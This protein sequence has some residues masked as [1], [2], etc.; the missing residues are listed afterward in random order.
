MKKLLLSF[1][2]LVVLGVGAYVW[3]CRIADDEI[4]VL[5]SGDYKLIEWEITPAVDSVKSVVAC[6]P[7]AIGS[8]VHLEYTADGKVSL[9]AKSD[10]GAFHPMLNYEWEL[11][12]PCR[13]EWF[14]PDYM[15]ECLYVSKKSEINPYR[16]SFWLRCG[17]TFG[18]SW[19][20]MS[21]YSRDPNNEQLKW[22][23]TFHK[24]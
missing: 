1:L 4:P 7:P 3:K 15:V 9:T 23:L 10:M 19:E 16:T 18:S 24:K 11:F 12:F 8:V 5:L 20:S 17:R 2:A 6:T 14:I 13:K 21:L 22:Q